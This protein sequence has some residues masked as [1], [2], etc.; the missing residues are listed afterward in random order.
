MAPSERARQIPEAEPEHPW[1]RVGRLT[2]RQ[3]IVIALCLAPLVLAVKG[4]NH[5]VGLGVSDEWKWGRSAIG[6]LV[7]AFVLVF[8]ARWLERRRPLRR[9]AARVEPSPPAHV[10]VASPGE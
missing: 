2:R 5:L 10:D 9:D 8:V 1:N 4:L 7:F 6:A 3:A